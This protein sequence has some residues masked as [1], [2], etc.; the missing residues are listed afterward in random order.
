MS[1]INCALCLSQVPRLIKNIERRQKIAGLYHSHLGDLAAVRLPDIELPNG[2]MHV[3]PIRA[4]FDFD[5]IGKTRKQIMVELAGHGI[6]TQVHYP[7]LSS[8]ILP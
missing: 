4:A 6:G 7:S 8:P 5:Q 2:A 3:A 1:E